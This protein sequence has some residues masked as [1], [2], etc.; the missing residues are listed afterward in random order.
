[1]VAFL[2]KNDNIEYWPA[3]IRYFFKHSIVL[4]QG[5]TEHV[6]AL[7]DWYGKHNKKDYFNV[8]RRGLSRTL[9]GV[10]QNGMKHVELWKPL[11]R[12]L[13]HESIIPVQR[14]VCRFMKAKYCPQNNRT[15]LIAVIPLNR[16]FSVYY[17][18]LF[19][20]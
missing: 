18:V 1:M 11:T 14:I 4:P 19:Q 5:H 7:V 16:R 8:P 9:D 3:T 17:I 10:A 20:I 2:D 12:K 15:D 6:L 13:S